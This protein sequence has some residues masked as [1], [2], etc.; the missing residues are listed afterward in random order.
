MQGEDECPLSYYYD[1]MNMCRVINPN[2]S[3]RNKLDYL[4]QGLKKSLFTEIYTKRPDTCAKFLELLKL[5]TE[6][7]DIARK[8]GLY[9]GVLSAEDKEELYSSEFVGYMNN[10][11][12]SATNT[13]IESLMKEIRDLKSQ[14]G[15]VQKEKQTN[16]ANKDQNP[17]L[18]S[19]SGKRKAKP[20][21]KN[22]RTSDGRNICYRC[23]Q[24]GHIRR[25]CNKEPQGAKGSVGDKPSPG[26]GPT[27]EPT[28]LVATIQL[29]TEPP[30]FNTMSEAL[31]REMELDD[32][33]VQDIDLTAIFR[34]DL[35][36]LITE[37][38][39]CNGSPITAVIDTGAAISVMS[40][41]AMSEIGL[42]LERWDGPGVTM[43]NDQRGTPLGAVDV[44]IVTTQGR[45]MGRIIVM[46]MEYVNLLLGNDLL[47][48][49]GRIVID[50]PAD[51]PG[52]L[53]A[54]LPVGAINLDE[55]NSTSIQ[56]ASS[57]DILIP[58]RVTQAVVVQG[59]DH[60]E[61]GLKLLT[62]APALYETK[63]LTTGYVI[64][65]GYNLQ[66]VLVTN[67]STDPVWLPMGAIV[68][69]V[70]DVQ[71]KEIIPIDER[72]SNGNNQHPSVTKEEL[73][74]RLG[75][76]LTPDEQEAA[77]EVL[78]KHSKCFA[79]S[80]IELGRCPWVEH[81]IDT[82]DA[83][84]IA[85]PPYKSAWKEREEILN[86]VNKMKSQGIIED[87]N[88]PWSSPVVLVKKPDGTWRFCV[89]YRKL[90]SV[91]VDSVYPLPIIADAL[92]RLEGATLF[93]LMDLQQG[94]HQLTVA[95]DDC[96]K[97]A[98]VTADGLYQFKVLP[99]GL[100]GAPARF[101][102]TMDLVLAGLRW[103][104]C[105]VYIDDVVVWG[106][107]LS[108]HLERLD[109]VLTCLE[110]AGLKL[111]IKKCRFLESVLKI[112]G[113]IVSRFGI[114]P[115]PE[116]VKAVSEFPEPDLIKND[117]ANIKL[118]QSFV[119]ICSYYR[120]HVEGFS[121]IARPLTELTKKDSVFI[122]EEEQRKS[123][124]S[125][126][127]ALCNVALLNFPRYELPME[128]Y[129]DACGYGLGATLSQKIDGIEKPLCFASRLVSKSEAN[130]SITELE[131]LALVWALKKFRNYIW[132][133]K[134]LVYTDHSALCWLMTKRDLAGRLARWKLSIQEH[135]ITIIYRSGK[136]H[137]NGDSLSRYPVDYPENEEEEDVCLAVATV[138]TF[139]DK[140]R[141][142][143]WLKREQKHCLWWKEIIKTLSGGG[144]HKNFIFKDGILYVRTFHHDRVVERL[145]VPKCLRFDICSNYHEDMIAGHMGMTRTRNRICSRYFWPNMT[146]EINRFVRSC[147]SC[148]SRKG[149]LRKPAGF[150]QSIYVEKPFEKVGIDLLGP[151]PLSGTGKRNII[152]AVDYLTKWVEAAALP[153][154]TTEDVVKFFMEYV[155]FRHGAP[156]QIITDRGKCFVSE[157]A[158]SV[159]QVLQTNHKTTVAYHPQAN[160]QVEK[161]N[162]ILAQML[163]MYVDSNQRNWDII[164][165]YVVFAYNTSVQESTGYTPFFLLYGREAKTP[166]DLLHQVSSDP[167]LS[168]EIAMLPLADRIQRTLKETRQSVC[169]RMERVKAEQKRRYDETRREL[170][171]S[172]GD[173]VLVYKPIRKVGKSDKLLHRWLGPY[174]V[175]RELSP[176]NY[177]VKLRS[178]R[179]KSDIVHV[180]KMKP[181]FE[182]QH[183]D[184]DCN[185]ED[186]NDD[187]DKENNPP[188]EKKM[189]ITTPKEIVEESG[190][191]HE[192]KRGE[193]EET[194][195][196]KEST[197]PMGV[198]RSARIREI[199]GKKRIP[200]SLIIPYMICFAMIAF[201]TASPII[202]RGG[203]LFKE[204]ANIAFSE[205]TWTLVYPIWL[206]E[207]D[208][209][210]D[211]IKRWS[212]RQIQT[213]PEKMLKKHNGTV[214]GAVDLNY[215]L[216]HVL[217]TRI[218]RQCETFVRQMKAL[219]QRI[220]MLKNLARNPIANS[221]LRIPKNK[222]SI[223]DFG[224]KVF[225]WL[226]GVATT[227]DLNKIAQAVQK[228]TSKRSQIYQMLDLQ[229]SVINDV[230]G[231]TRINAKSISEL[232]E[233]ILSL[234][235]MFDSA[236]AK[237]IMMIKAETVMEEVSESI[238]WL[239]HR[240]DQ[241][242]NGI[243]TLTHG[244][245]SSQS[246]SPLQLRKVLDEVED[247][248]SPGWSFSTY[249]GRGDTL[250]NTYRDAKVSTG[251]VGNQL[252]IYISIPTYELSTEF[253]LYQV[254]NLPEISNDNQHQLKYT[255]L[256]DFIAVSNDRDRYLEL[257][258]SDV[259]G[260]LG[261]HSK[262]CRFHTPIAKSD[263][264]S[265]CAFA[266]FKNEKLTQAQVCKTEVSDWKGSEVIYLDHHRWG[267]TDVSDQELVIF[268]PNKGREVRRL[269]PIGIFEIPVGCEAR[270]REWIFPTNRQVERFVSKDIE[271]N[272]PPMNVFHDLPEVISD[273]NS[274]GVLHL[275]PL[276]ESLLARVKKVLEITNK[277]I[278]RIPFTQVELEDRFTAWEND[279]NGYVHLSWEWMLPVITLIGMT[280]YLFL[281]QR[282]TEEKIRVLM[283]RFTHHENLV[284]E[285]QRQH[286]N[287]YVEPM[288]R[289]NSLPELYVSR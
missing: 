230:A 148:Q 178:G 215:E 158:K 219:E 67:F 38:V 5:H 93:S 243:V 175:L 132:G 97:T 120:R 6:A 95:K 218:V 87:S 202:A 217:S 72:G 191:L 150:L 21:P 171:F 82:G 161:I 164:L 83:Q 231:A 137:V 176:I 257:R 31:P 223:F 85:Q 117:T 142:P 156:G 159:T 11:P 183:G 270:L 190:D 236:I 224:G 251:I 32:S 256:P 247:K 47:S 19:N 149:V 274:P 29:D 136:L 58:P 63:G 68:A 73:R 41:R 122:W 37:E 25:F 123:F 284:M 43:A 154:G 244:Q 272:T 262:I 22:N 162:H 267:I 141:D 1:V 207:T 48:Q 237:S 165:P 107:T 242:E 152:V 33:E 113:H 54:E 79:A 205:S 166:L 240:V 273:I 233:R 193:G 99:F 195:S 238:T 108:Q 121:K 70:E 30:L 155:F 194:L 102:K 177:E 241:L 78:Y 285:E 34:V 213:I 9:V 101:Q 20:P 53:L 130:Y 216:M 64:I 185:D 131:C 289:T 144:R 18:M 28:S 44:D 197:I 184:P 179:G 259:L 42:K 7:G 182:A 208:P 222:R 286:R 119:G 187:S 86:Q 12:S 106:S 174:L 269:P 279:R 146:E 115:D 214:G 27:K 227:N 234:E 15:R 98:F 170:K 112:L 16:D 254:I 56:L 66:V 13:T 221:N 229:A 103:T 239:S 246:F 283:D 271:E 260:C 81:E 265:S 168:E 288:P 192:L 10:R 163:S 147:P 92:N 46:Q 276:N 167:L 118:I 134:V 287:S 61:E 210:I 204:E 50:Y 281:K 76:E 114:A 151:F 206:N 88:S 145:C 74:S 57:G 188:G 180:C 232:G 26:Q 69:H 116:K 17:N 199:E 160:G 143:D 266:L 153:T 228:E 282:Q 94:Y 3:E 129:P 275:S 36:R 245:L 268:C 90:N 124:Q 186:R 23:G 250:W 135:D 126:K 200:L 225:K 203:V 139:K 248:L 80:D 201:T 84:P 96:Q 169:L 35:S 172:E 196:K 212:E 133:C 111:K 55:E 14:L 226:F 181:Y 258:K 125:L 110:R 252:Q 127:K 8:K 51:G 211:L 140:G 280:V 261:I 264:R 105:L 59:L 91:T 65:P 278:G 128:I 189:I 263:T 45:V 49:M 198:R 4:Y 209:Y 89:D 220:D 249:R 138:A 157:L 62:P 71:G 255:N 24:P 39:F 52:R 100:K 60:L 173:L 109:Q 235:A 40:P 77:L 75:K 2:M 253:T 104:S 277:T